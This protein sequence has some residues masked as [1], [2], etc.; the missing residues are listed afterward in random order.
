MGRAIGRAMIAAEGPGLAAS[1]RDEGEDR[2]SDEEM[3][4]LEGATMAALREFTPKVIE[5]LTPLYATG[6]TE[7]ELEAIV[8]FYE[9]PVGRRIAAKSSELMNQGFKAME[10]LAPMLEEDIWRRVCEKVACEEEPAE[11]PSRS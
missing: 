8:A 9:S 11:S 6:F 5:Q 1:M 7:A 10:D 3:V 4:I 2:L